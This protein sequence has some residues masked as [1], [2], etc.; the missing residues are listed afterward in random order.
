[1]F[2]LFGSGSEYERKEGGRVINKTCPACK[3]NQRF[4][5]VVKRE[6]VH[7]F[8]IPV[9]KSHDTSSSNIFK[10]PNCEKVYSFSAMNSQSVFE[11]LKAKSGFS[12]FMKKRKQ[13]KR[14][15]DVDKELA[16]LKSELK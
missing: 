11:S 8:F 6:Y 5:E 10:C 15:N 1:M 16:R 14:M 2:V 3:L 12:S 7:I 4:Y 9:M 13:K